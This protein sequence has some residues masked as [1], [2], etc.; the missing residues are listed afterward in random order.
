MTTILP[1]VAVLEMTYRCNH[2][3]RF[4]SCPWFA[5]MLKPG[6]EMEVDEW[7]RLIEAMRLRA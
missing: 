4:C 1:S 2:A 3:C 5:G 7:K 6:L